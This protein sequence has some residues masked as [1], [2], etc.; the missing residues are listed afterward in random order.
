MPS[1]PS[2]LLNYCCFE[3]HLLIMTLSSNIAPLW[4]QDKG[5]TAYPG[6]RNVWTQGFYGLDLKCPFV[7]ALDPSLALLTD[8]INL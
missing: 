3:L 4:Q 6:Y 1:L 8:G 2:K 7:K 5:K